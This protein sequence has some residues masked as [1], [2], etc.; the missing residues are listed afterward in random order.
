MIQEYIDELLDSEETRGLTDS[1]RK[2]LRR[3]LG[4]FSD[5]CRQKGADAAESLTPQFIADYM[6]TE[7][8]GKKFDN[9]KSYVWALRKLGHYLQFTGL[10]SDNIA[11]ALRH[12]RK[13]SRGPLADYLSLDEMRKLL[14]WC[15]EIGSKRDFA[16]VSL[17]CTNGLRPVDVA[18]RCGRR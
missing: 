2:D 8:A 3:L 17:M 6:L 14:T 18:S 10:L 11:S 7:H 12:P 1:T 4:K 13:P 5:Y 15:H 9:K 16:I